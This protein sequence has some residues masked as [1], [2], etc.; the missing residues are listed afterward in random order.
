MINRDELKTV[1]VAVTAADVQ[2]GTNVPVNMRR[3]IYRLE[4]IN[5][6]NAPNLFTLGKRENGAGATTNVG[7]VQAAVQF[8]MEADPA[9]L[10]EDSAPLFIVEGPA[11]SDVIIPVGASS[12]RGF[13]SGAGTG[14]VTLWYID[15]PA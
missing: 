5:T 8:Q 14:F 7:Y 12:V 15:A 11:S 2:I 3:F 9:E 1:A 13:C 6:I 4:F 10:H